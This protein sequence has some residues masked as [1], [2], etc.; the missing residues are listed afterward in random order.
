MTHGN[1]ID[2]N[3][4]DSDNGND[5]DNSDNTNGNC[6]DT[7]EG[8]DRTTLPEWFLRVQSLVDEEEDEIVDASLPKSLRRKRRNVKLGPWS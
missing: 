4:D 7:D 8:D 5:S 1:D 6:S 3:V 2:A